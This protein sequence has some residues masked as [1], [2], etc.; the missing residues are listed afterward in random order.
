MKEMLLVCHTSTAK[1]KEPYYSCTIEKE[2]GSKRR[3][4]NHPR[5]IAIK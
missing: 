1:K 3:I 2:K 5:Q 4:V